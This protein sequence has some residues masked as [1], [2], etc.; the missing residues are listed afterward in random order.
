MRLYISITKPNASRKLPSCMWVGNGWGAAFFSRDTESYPWHSCF[1][2]FSRVSRI[3][4]LAS[5]TGRINNFG[6]SRVGIFF[7]KKKN[8]Q[9]A[10]PLR[11]F[12]G[13]WAHCSRGFI[14]LWA[15]CSLDRIG[16]WRS[17]WAHEVGEPPTS[18]NVKK[19]CILIF[20]KILFAHIYIYIYIY[21]SIP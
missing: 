10:G 13:L 17:F 19:K 16:F 1:D 18:R 21:I 7:S 15:H 2:I 4:F 14:G 12:I 20:A 11:G 3:T 6:V 9:G 8:A 5:I